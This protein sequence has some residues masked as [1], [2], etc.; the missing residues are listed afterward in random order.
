MISTT[1]RV[2]LA[3][4]KFREA[5]NILDGENDQRSAVDSWILHNLFSPFEAPG[6]KVQMEVVRRGN[7]EHLIAGT[8][9][10]ASTLTVLIV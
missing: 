10:A 2:E 5:M 1:I 9:L 4:R 7:V 3:K 8:F 6:F